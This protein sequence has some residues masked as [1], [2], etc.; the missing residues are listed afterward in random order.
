MP[1]VKMSSDCGRRF[2]SLLARTHSTEGYRRFEVPADRHS[3]ARSKKRPAG[4]GMTDESMTAG[5]VG[6]PADD[7]DKR[8]RVRGGG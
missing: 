7:R 6:N 4:P 3:Q 1:M 2:C 5:L 8:R